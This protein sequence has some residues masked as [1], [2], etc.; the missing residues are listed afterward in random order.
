ME[1]TGG[2]SI[3]GLKYVCSYKVPDWRYK[4]ERSG[5]ITTLF[6]GK[7]QFGSITPSDDISA[8]KWIDIE[9]INFDKIKDLIVEEHVYLME[10]LLNQII[11]KKL[12]F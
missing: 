6:A 9:D 8:L 12:N 1:E 4:N 3:D 11:N 10:E 2:C 7:F 5:I